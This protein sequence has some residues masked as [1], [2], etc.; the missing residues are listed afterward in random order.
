MVVKKACVAL[1]MAAWYKAS[2][3]LGEVACLIGLREPLFQTN[4]TLWLVL[5]LEEQL[6]GPILHVRALRNGIY[7]SKLFEDSQILLKL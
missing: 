1:E 6:S 5:K 3:K 4:H 2:D 7:D